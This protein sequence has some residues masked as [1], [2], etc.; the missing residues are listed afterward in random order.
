MAFS[1]A[2]FFEILVARRRAVRW[3]D[4]LQDFRGVGDSKPRE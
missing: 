3:L 4:S 2:I 1:S